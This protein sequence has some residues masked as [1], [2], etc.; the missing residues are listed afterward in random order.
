MLRDEYEHLIDKSVL[1]WLATA[2]ADGE[3]SV[4]PKEIFTH[5]GGTSLIIANIASPRSAKNVRENPRVCVSCLD[6]FTQKGLQLRGSAQLVTDKDPGF[7][8]LAEPLTAMASGRFPFVSLFEVTIEAVKPILAP[9]YVFYPETTEDQQVRNAM[10]SY[11][12][13]P[14]AAS[15][16]SGR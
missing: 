10:Q 11:G 16:A 8:S 2:S 4:S 12:V 13:R 7:S 9:S 5:R 14:G 15:S 6:V 1:C 3:P